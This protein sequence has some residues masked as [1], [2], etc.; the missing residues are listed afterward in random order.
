[1]AHL[2]ASN[3]TNFCCSPK[4]LTITPVPTIRSGSSDAFVEGLDLVK[5][6]FVRRPGQGDAAFKSVFRQFTLLCKRLDL[7]GRELL[8]VDGT[9]IKAVNNKDRN[10]TQRSLEKFIEAADERLADYLARLDEGDV[11]EAGMNGSRTKN[12]VA[13]KRFAPSLA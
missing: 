4:R 11:A 10:F 8:A 2:P 9:R 7:F 6:G 13:W 3:A 5:A 1:M 12:C